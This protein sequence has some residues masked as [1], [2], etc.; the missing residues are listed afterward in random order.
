MTGPTRVLIVE[1]DQDLRALLARGLG[2]EG[3]EIVVA[4]NG[5]EAV[6]AAGMCPDAVVLDIGL[7]DADGR[8]VLQALRARG[9]TAPVIF[10]TARDAVSDRLSAFAVGG[11]DYLTKPFAF[12]ELLAR[13]DALLH[14]ANLDQNEVS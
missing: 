2:K 7:P 9:V 3:Y 5:G 13:L 11:D 1:D 14:R 4:H 6:R 8:D 10:L 12:A